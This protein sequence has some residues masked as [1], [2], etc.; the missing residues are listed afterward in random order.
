MGIPL[1]PPPTQTPP[2]HDQANA[3]VLNNLGTVAAGDPMS[4]Y[5]LFNAALS[6]T[7]S[8]TARLERTFDGGTTYIPAFN[9]NTGS[10]VASTAPC[11]FTL[12][13][14]ERGVSWRWN[15]TAYT[16]G[17]ISAR[18]SATGVV[19]TSNGIP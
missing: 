12:N 10:V 14:P 19:A 7:F 13:E 16:S 3:V 17:T 1:T 11:S 6:G 2:A 8:A 18:L 9:V 4:V 15:C 5:G